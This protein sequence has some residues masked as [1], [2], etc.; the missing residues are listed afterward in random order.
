MADSVKAAPE[1][2]PDAL[3]GIVLKIASVFVF[4]AMALIIKVTASEV[5]VGEAVFF[6]S[7]FG[8]PP[9]I[10]WLVW[11]KDFPAGILTGNP[12]GHFWRGL[13]GIT[14][15]ALSFTA[16][17][18]L[19]YPEVVAIGYAAPVF[20]TILAAMFLGERVRMFRL[21]AIAVGLV[22]VLIILYPK[23]TVLT[24]NDATAVEAVGAMMALTAAM[25]AA[26]AQVFVRQL[27]QVER[28]AA[29]VFWFHVTGAVLA[30]LTLFFGWSRPGPLNASLLVL[31]GI[32]GGIGQVML[33]E[34]YRHAEV[35]VIAPFEYVSVIL[36]IA[37]GYFLFGEVLTPIMFAGVALIVAAG[38]FIIYRERRLGLE[39]ARARRVMTPQG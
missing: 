17:G 36:A 32:L 27:V 15:M 4:T 21:G 9:I 3:R 30:L 33:T 19:A 26:V 16:L 23:M 10:L 20:V 38:L 34:S 24:E 5:P 39:R 2:L 28:A 7:L 37:A 13:A 31:A 22:G 18:L 35:G 1:F 29:I 12:M 8:I 14:A 11:R 25:C 6:R